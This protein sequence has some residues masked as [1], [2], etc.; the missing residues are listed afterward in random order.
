MR[1]DQASHAIERVAGALSV[2]RARQWIHFIVLPAAALD[3]AA[4]G[5]TR[6]ALRLALSVTTA[7]LALGYA[8]GVNA[9]AD[10]GTD[11]SSAKNPLAGASSVPAEV[12]AV[13]ATT[14]GSAI[15][16]SLILGPFALLLTLASLTAA[17]FYSV[18]PRMKALPILGLVFNTGIFAPLLGL[19]I[20]DQGAPASYGVLVST[21]VALILQNQL[22]HESADAR[23]DARGGV[24]TTA[25]LLG[26]RGTKAAVLSIAA[27]GMTLAVALAPTPS[28][29]VAAGSAIA[30]GSAAVGLP[31]SPAR[32]RLAH[33]WLSAAGGVVLFI[34]GLLP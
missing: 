23:E 34:A 30:L 29:A 22:L 5:S 21:F 25:R 6:G 32:A 16:M 33:R 15:A 2:L 19:A 24:L 3:L 20:S 28:M 27:P 11:E 18:G 31:G 10:R 14:A 17:T 4:L 7:A 26:P 9:L 12:L 13:V 1:V 8:Y